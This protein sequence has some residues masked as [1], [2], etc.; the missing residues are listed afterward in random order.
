MKFF[1]TRVSSKHVANRF[2][3]AVWQWFSHLL[4]LWHCV[5]KSKFGTHCTCTCAITG[6]Y[7]FNKNELQHTLLPALFSDKLLL[8]KLYS[9]K[10]KLLFE[11]FI[12]FWIFLVVQILMAASFSSLWLQHSGLTVRI[13]VWHFGNEY[14][15]Y[16]YQCNAS[17]LL[18]TCYLYM[19]NITFAMAT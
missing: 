14:K 16:N 15:V 8:I 5:R 18:M 7:Y 19:W 13:H 11:I 6:W 17:T 12:D 1:G 2:L 3:K 10:W 4:N 9:N